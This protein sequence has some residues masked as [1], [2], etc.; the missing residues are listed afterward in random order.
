[1]STTSNYLILKFGVAIFRAR[2]KTGVIC[3]NYT[4]LSKPG[5]K[6]NLEFLLD[7]K[8]NDFDYI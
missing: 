6:L 4:T 8:D 1:M 7:S 3:P 5:R 2:T